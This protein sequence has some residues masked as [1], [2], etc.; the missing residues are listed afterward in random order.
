MNNEFDKQE[1]VPEEAPFCQSCGMP[2]TR[3][4]QFGTEADGSRSGDYCV[5][6]YRDGAFTD[7]RTMEEMIDFCL[8]YEKDSGLYSDR[9]SAR[10]A[11][12]AWFPTLKRWNRG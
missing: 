10:R 7:D 4:D 2:M 9:E 5:Y 8:D 6:C 11:M 12:L 3:E 1:T